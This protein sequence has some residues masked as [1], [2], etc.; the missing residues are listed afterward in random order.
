MGDRFWSRFG[1]LL[2]R[3]GR[4]VC[5][6]HCQLRLFQLELAV[7]D[8]YRPRLDRRVAG[9]VDA[10]VQLSELARSTSFGPMPGGRYL[11]GPRRL[12]A[13]RERRGIWRISP[14]SRQTFEHRL[15]EVAA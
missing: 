12:C 8:A 1:R 13:G 9:F 10:Q 2:D 14:D 11:P 3:M 15:L 4:A 5:F 6:Q 7:S